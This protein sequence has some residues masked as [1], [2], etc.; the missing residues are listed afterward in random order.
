MKDSKACEKLGLKVN[1]TFPQASKQ[2]FRLKHLKIHGKKDK[3]NERDGY[4]TGFL[5]LPSKH[6]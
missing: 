4:I 6:K 1:T 2:K 3:Q 5:S